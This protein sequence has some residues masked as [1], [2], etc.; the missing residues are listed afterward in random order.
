[1]FR[2]KAVLEY[3]RRSIKIVRQLLDNPK[4]LKY[5]NIIYGPT[6]KWILIKISK[7]KDRPVFTLNKVV[8]GSYNNSLKRQRSFINIV[9]TK[10]NKGKEEIRIVQYLSPK[11]VIIHALDK[12]KRNG[13]SLRCSFAFISYEKSK[14]CK[15]VL[16]AIKNHILIDRIFVLIQLYNAYLFFFTEMRYKQ[17][18]SQKQ[19]F[20]LKRTAL[21]SPPI[22]LPSR[23]PPFFCI[24]GQVFNFK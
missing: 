10:I 8:D 21:L 23:P 3:R 4:L 20:K 7:D 11:A 2:L 1:M 5:I 15:E 22:L 18:L 13:W 24:I 19:N 9:Q 17:N 16:K 12:A 14:Q 6:N